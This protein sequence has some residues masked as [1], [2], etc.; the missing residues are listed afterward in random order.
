MGGE[1]GRPGNDMG[2]QF[3]FFVLF[4]VV[5]DCDRVQVDLFRVRPLK[6]YVPVPRVSGATSW[7]RG[8]V[9]VVV[10]GEGGWCSHV[11]GPRGFWV[12]LPP[13]VA[14]QLGHPSCTPA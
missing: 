10:A 13:A 7:T 8:E 9:E 14:V 12:H 2:G 6:S 3:P 4:S 11:R 5:W 1:K